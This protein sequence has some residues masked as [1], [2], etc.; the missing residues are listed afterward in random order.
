[1]SFDLDALAQS[2]AATLVAA[3]ATEL[4]QQTRRRAASVLS[5]RD[6]RAEQ[7]ML[8]QLEAS[9]SRLQ[10]APEGEDAQ[11]EAG[12]R[13][14]LGYQLHRDPEVAGEFAE[15]LRELARDGVAAAPPSYSFTQQATVGQNG[16]SVQA[17]RNAN[18]SGRP[19]RWWSK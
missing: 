13:A 8:D 18:V 6:S 12:V 10:A 7:A 2:G 15:L 5:S 11:V 19:R 3:M 9:R 1:M 17:G 14:L 16:F 4:W